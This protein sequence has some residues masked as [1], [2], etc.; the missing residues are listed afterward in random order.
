MSHIE[1]PRHANIHDCCFGETYRTNLGALPR[2]IAP[3][4]ADEKTLQAPTAANADRS[5]RH[6]CID[7]PPLPATVTGSQMVCRAWRYMG[8]QPGEASHEVGGVYQFTCPLCGGELYLAG[9]GWWRNAPGE[10]RE[11]A[12][13]SLAASQLRSSRETKV[14][15]AGSARRL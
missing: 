13:I 14:R 11:E 4:G 6:I 5:A 10:A 8:A 1:Y 2:S 9:L 7:P 15:S 3:M 12:D